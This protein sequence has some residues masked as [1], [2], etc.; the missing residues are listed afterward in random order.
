MLFLLI[1]FDLI[2]NFFHSLLCLIHFNLNENK[3]IGTELNCNFGTNS[4]YYLWPTFKECRVINKNFPSSTKNKRFTFS[5]SIKEKN[6]TTA[7]Y[8]HSSPSIDFIPFQIF[9]EFPNLNGILITWSN[10]PTLTEGFF[11]KDF[12]DIQYLS[13]YF[14]NIDQIEEFALINLTELKWIYLGS[15]QIESIKTNIFK[16]NQ[17]LEFIGLFSNKIKMIHPNL[18]VNLNNL[19]EVW[20]EDNECVSNG[21]GGSRNPGLTTMKN[22]L[23]NCYQN[24]LNDAECAANMIEPS[25]ATTSTTTTTTTKENSSVFGSVISFGKKFFG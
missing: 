24:C 23:D 16:N 17:K 12:K 2:F 4:F 6:Y 11:T 1:A 13:L 21:F 3:V 15:N 8:F 14:N 19:V 5:G 22:T 7:V 18:F 9:T 10:I 25:T 20:L